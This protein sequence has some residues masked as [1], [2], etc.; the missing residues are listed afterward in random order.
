M[1]VRVAICDYGV[2]NLRS[3][4]RALL[5]AGADVVLTGDAGE[6]RSC[7]GVVLPGVGAF[8]A[9][10]DALEQTGLGDVVVDIAR[11]GTPLLAVCLGHQ[12]LFEESDENGGRRGLG[13]LPGRVVRLGPERGKVPHMGWNQ[14]HLTRPTPLFSGVAEGAY[15]YFVHSYA[16]V[17]GSDAIAAVT[18]YGGEMVAACALGNVWSTQ[19][20]PE[21]SGTTGL[22]IYANFVE[23]ARNSLVQRIGSPMASGS[24][25]L[26]PDAGAPATR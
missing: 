5:H 21:K 25:D 11:S 24:G 6:M 2:G 9:A 1:S 17:T 22:R 3:V 26:Q 18:D 23:V 20:H 15:V 13:L 12:I 19:F 7:A 4:E 8:G 14:L 16:A 10:M